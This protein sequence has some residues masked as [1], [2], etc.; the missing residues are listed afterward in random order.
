LGAG[1]RATKEYDRATQLNPA[2][3][4]SVKF[5]A[6]QAEAYRLAGDL[7][8]AGEKIRAAINGSRAANVTAREKQLAYN[9]GGNL[10]YDVAVKYVAAGQWDNAG[11]LFRSTKVFY[12]SAKVAAHEEGYG[13]IS[14]RN[15]LNANMAIDANSAAAPQLRKLMGTYRGVVSFPAVS[16]EGSATIVIS[17][18]RFSLVNCNA[19]LIGSIVPRQQRG[20]SLFVDLIFDS[21]MPIKQLSLRA[22]SP[23]GKRLTISNVNTEKNRFVFST[24]VKPAPLDCIR[25]QIANN[26]DAPP[27]CCR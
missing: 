21:T 9:A 17:G 15:L 27:D 7:Q 25:F 16:L 4:S 18:N 19:W 20:D 8:K 2:L 3:Q 26:P 1:R 23:D 11:T 13:W 24:D 10:S 5:L 14:E 22:V 6:S 12:E